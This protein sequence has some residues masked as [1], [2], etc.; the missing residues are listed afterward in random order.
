MGEAFTGWALLR[1]AM[2][3]SWA[4]LSPLMSRLGPLLS[5]LKPLQS[6]SVRHKALQ[7]QFMRTFLAATLICTYQET[8]S[9]PLL[10]MATCS[11]KHRHMLQVREA[12]TQTFGISW[13]RPESKTHAFTSQQG[14]K[15]Y[16]LLWSCPCQELSAFVCQ[17]QQYSAC[18]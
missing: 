12:G 13:S 3:S 14:A 1:A 8:S 4:Q 5:R 11:K 7:S 17:S 16:M 2:M 18:S 9:R 15:A 10:T 6:Q